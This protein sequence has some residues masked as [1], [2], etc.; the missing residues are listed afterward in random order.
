[1][2]FGGEQ[3]RHDDR[4]PETRRGSSCSGDLVGPHLRLQGVK[5]RAV[6]EQELYVERLHQCDQIVRRHFGQEDRQT[7]PWSDVP[8]VVEQLAYGHPDALAG[9]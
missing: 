9:R 4:S 1:M 3:R 7:G 6:L 8:S 2:I 5:L